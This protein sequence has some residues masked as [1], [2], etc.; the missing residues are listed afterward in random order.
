MPE[1]ELCAGNQ[2]QK[3]LHNILTTQ[4]KVNEWPQVGMD[5]SGKMVLTAVAQVLFEFGL[6]VLLCAVWEHSS[7]PFFPN[8]TT[9]KPA[10]VEHALDDSA[11]S[12]VTKVIL[13]TKQFWLL[14]LNHGIE[15]K[16]F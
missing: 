12:L 7:P 2:K 6:S 15:F 1:S 10:L 13:S 9:G 14:K 5:Q 4:H 16:W 8:Q 11:I 3:I